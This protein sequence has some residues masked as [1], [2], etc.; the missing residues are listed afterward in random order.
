MV[1][2]P[3]LRTL[4]TTIV[5]DI[6]R[7]TIVALLL[8]GTDPAAV[9]TILRC[10]FVEVASARKEILDLKEAWKAGPSEVRACKREDC[11]LPDEREALAK[12]M[13]TAWTKMQRVSPTPAG[14]ARENASP[15]PRFHQ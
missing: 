12:A 4:I 3:D 1:D 5:P 10:T 7:A 14:K 13:R 9:A 11:P 15:G 6:H 2:T 8:R